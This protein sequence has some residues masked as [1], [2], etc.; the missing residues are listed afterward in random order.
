MALA[1]KNILLGF[2]AISTFLL[3]FSY[4][5][6]PL[7]NGD[8]FPLNIPVYD[9]MG[10]SQILM[11]QESIKGKIVLVEFWASWCGKCLKQAK[12]LDSIAKRYKH[13]T[14]KGGNGLELVRISLDENQVKWQTFISNNTEKQGIDFRVDSAWKSDY[15]QQTGFSYL[16][17]I[18]VINSEGKILSQGLTGA[19]L[20]RKLDSLINK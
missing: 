19:R 11:E 15:V 12:S 3:S 10:Q 8:I 4:K 18:Y 2:V 14:F 17:Y 20:G 16:P 6:K 5:T 1:S 7:Q 13:E 9:S